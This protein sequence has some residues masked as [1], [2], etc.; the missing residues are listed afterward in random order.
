VPLWKRKKYKNCCLKNYGKPA[1]KISGIVVDH[2]RRQIA[3]INENILLNRLTRDVPQIEAS[4]DKLCGADL[5]AFSK[6]S[7]QVAGVVFGG[8]AHATSHDDELRA[9]CA[10]LMINCLNT[11]SAA[12]LTLRAG[13]LL[14]PGILARNIVETIAVV[15]HLIQKREDLPLFRSGKIPSQRAISSAKEIIPTFGHIY[16]YLSNEYTHIGTLHY[17][18]QAPQPYR[19]LTEPLT[20]NLGLLRVSLWVM[21]V[22]AEL[23]FIDLLEHPRYWENL[24]GGAFR[25]APS[26]RERE[27]QKDFLGSVDID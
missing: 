24:G 14:G 3:L 15:A 26:D 22:T 8:L 13:Y 12:L 27:W 17:S 11:F 23:L 21:Y 1:R 19:S 9:Q 6:L 25:Y 7:S 16:G 18:I 2:S 5:E 10:Q 4:F 20:I